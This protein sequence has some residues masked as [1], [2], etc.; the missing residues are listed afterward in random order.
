MTDVIAVG[1][2]GSEPSLLA[3]RW[4]R[5]EAGLRQ[6][7]LIAV[8][9]RPSA[10]EWP[11]DSPQHVDGIN[12]HISDRMAQIRAAIALTLSSAGQGAGGPPP[13]GVNTEA[14]TE[15]TTEPDTQPDTQADTQPDMQADTQPDSQSDTQPHTQHEPAAG[16]HPGPAVEPEIEIIEGHPTTVLVTVS[17]RVDL[18]VVGGR[19]F[20]GWKGAFAGSL[21]DH[22]AGHTRAPLAVIRSYAPQPRGRIV[23][24]VDGVSSSEAVR[25]GVQEAALRGASMLVVSTW[26]YPVL[27]T[28]PT[29][30][31]AAELLESGAR[32]LLEEAIAACRIEH[33]QVPLDTLV[34]MGHPAE[35]LAEEAQSADLVMVGS[36]GRGGF[37]SLILGS[38]AISVLH[39]VAGPV[40]VVPRAA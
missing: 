17:K 21:T 39:R 1:V 29:S 40:V 19:G 6:A 38:V 18:L 4:A 2:D 12:R 10:L 33:P 28:R 36:R 7:R 22:L 30:P 3:L 14:N 9:A 27:G 16:H 13:D 26:Q 34:R 32:A 35:V 31:E 25:F 37:A 24:G 23:V 15:A 11:H 5:V 8:I 20:G